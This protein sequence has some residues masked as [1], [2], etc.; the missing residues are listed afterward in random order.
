[1][2]P[3]ERTARV[4]TA[5]P[6]ALNFGERQVQ[7]CVD[8]D[9]DLGSEPEQQ[10]T[11]DAGPGEQS[12]LAPGR[13]QPHRAL[14]MLAPDDVVE[15]HLRG[16]A[17]EH[18][19]QAVDHEQRR[20]MPDLQLPGHEQ[21]APGDR[22]AREQRHAELDHA[23]RIEAV[24]HRAGRHRQEQERQPVRDHREAAQRGRIEAFVDHPVADHVLDVVGHH[25]QRREQEVRPIA[26]V[27][28]GGERDGRGW[29]GRGHRDGGS[30]ATPRR[31][32]RCA[33]DR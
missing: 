9:A 7:A 2:S 21:H 25:R 29:G 32:K 6:A 24:G 13:I 18:A 10:S 8:E 28:Q 23:P 16:G 27:A 20:G 15:E 14:Q 1:M 17:P 4:A 33:G 11:A 22:H 12:E 31:G 30:S 26:A 3:S 5:A 19:R